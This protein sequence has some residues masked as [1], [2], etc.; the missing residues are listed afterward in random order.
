MRDKKETKILPLR[1]T[2]KNGALGVI[3]T[4]DPQVRNLML[5]INS[6]MT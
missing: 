6:V 1:K 3:R 4:P 2:L 5:S